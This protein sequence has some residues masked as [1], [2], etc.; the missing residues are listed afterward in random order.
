[1]FNRRN[2]LLWHSPLRHA[3]RLFQS[4][5]SGC[6]RALFLSDCNRTEASRK[7]IMPPFAEVLQRGNSARICEEKGKAYRNSHSPRL[8]QRI[9]HIRKGEMVATL[10]DV[11][12]ARGFLR[13]TCIDPCRR[14]GH[15][16]KVQMVGDSVRVHSLRLGDA[17]K[18]EVDVRN[19]VLELLW[20]KQR[21]IC[22]ARYTRLF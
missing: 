15:H 13:S 4:P 5:P 12:S 2:V 7:M 21:F 16:A 18:T 20:L 17:G 9:S 3:G 14:S 6:R 10:H 1:M 22:D 19:V 8:E 11:T